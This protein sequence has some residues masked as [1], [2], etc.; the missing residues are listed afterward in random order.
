HQ[1]T[2]SLTCNAGQLLL[3]YNDFRADASGIFEPYVVDL[4]ERPLRHTVD[5]RAAIAEPGSAPVF[6][7]SS[8][9]RS[10]QVSRY[11]SIVTVTGAAAAQSP[12]LKRTPPNLPMFELGH[13]PFFGDYVDVAGAP[14]FVFDGSAWRYNTA[15]ST[16][17]VYHAAWTDNRDVVGPPPP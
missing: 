4:P 10:Q 9:L 16:A 14:R 7:D 5:V 8:L 6:T 3:L 12:Q 15:A 1:L 17:P 2:P 13:K 11:P